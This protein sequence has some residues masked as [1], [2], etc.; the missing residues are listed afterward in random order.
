MYAILFWRIN[1][2]GDLVNKNRGHDAKGVLQVY[3]V[4]NVQWLVNLPL[5]I[6]YQ[7]CCQVNQGVS[8]ARG[9]QVRSNANSLGQLRS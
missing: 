9:H 2:S 3:M 6:P 4:N 7:Q 5:D 1:S 8:Y